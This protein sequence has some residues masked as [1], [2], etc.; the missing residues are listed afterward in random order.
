MR[1]RYAGKAA[2]PDLPG[3]HQSSVGAMGWAAAAEKLRLRFGHFARQRRAGTS[4]QGNRPGKTVAQSEP[5]LQGREELLRSQR[6]RSSNA[7]FETC[8]KGDL[9]PCRAQGPIEAG[10]PRVLPWADTLRA[11]SA[12]SMDSRRAGRMSQ[13]PGVRGT[14]TQ[15]WQYSQRKAARCRTCALSRACIPEAW[16][17]APACRRESRALDLSQ[18]ISRAMVR[19]AACCR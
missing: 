18:F 1:P 11:F 7:I 15:K 16:P 3:F 19:S 5:A 9:R 6:H 4:A 17:P 14:G 13:T 12:G 2:G 8:G 10:F